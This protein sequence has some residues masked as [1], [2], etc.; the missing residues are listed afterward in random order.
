[1]RLFLLIAFLFFIISVFSQRV[2]IEIERLLNEQSKKAL[3]AIIQLER[4]E[5]ET[6][7]VM[8]Y[9]SRYF[10]I[11]GDIEKSIV[12]AQKGLSR[13]EVEL[14]AEFNKQ[15]M[16]GHYLKGSEDSAIYYGQKL[17]NHSIS[18]T[19]KAKAN[20]LL[21][22][23]H[24]SLGNSSYAKEGYER[25]LNLSKETQD[26]NSV[27]SSLNGLGLIYFQVENQLDKAR[28][29]FFEAVKFTPISRPL[30]KANYLVNLSSVLIKQNRLDSALF[31][32]E[33]SE[34]IAKI[35]KDNGILFSCFV[36]KGVVLLSKNKLILAENYFKNALAL[37]ASPGVNQSDVE[38]LYLSWSDLEYEKGNYK[39]SRDYF[40]KYHELHESRV[41]NE[42]N[43]KIF[44]LQEQ[45]NAAEKKQQIA[46]LEI[47]QQKSE[48]KEKE[49]DAAYFKVRL[50]FLSV[51][52]ALII[53]SI[54]IYIL[55]R[56]RKL[57]AEKSTERE[58]RKAILEAVEKEKYRFSR[59]LHDSLGGTLSMSK[60]MASQLSDEEV[61]TKIGQLLQ[62][63]IDDTRRISRDLYPT[64]LKVSGLKA[65]VDNLFDNLRISN[66][67]VEF[68]FDMYDPPVKLS[69]SFSLHMYRVCQELTNNTIKYANAKNVVLEI[70]FQDQNMF[71]R[72]R[73]NGV[74]IDMNTYKTGV[75]M[76]S[77]QERLA[78]FNS[79]IEIISSVGKGFEISIQSEIEKAE[80]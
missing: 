18:T 79:S 80:E 40:Q 51:I 63:A 66:P 35:I 57:E 22:N 20:V 67:T 77:I 69:D 30:N 44:L 36:N 13:K 10:Q 33:K 14:S 16:I 37:I 64:V 72:Y 27:S 38:S 71:L 28:A 8:L 47:K 65:A 50:I 34:N 11:L 7:K 54:S 46:E 1:M 61:S 3:S 49:L 53:I 58:K 39:S 29:H 15:L 70:D 24:W 62:I 48:L 78:N 43:K 31:Y 23:A 19:E 56:R 55:F 76:N 21:A 74:G 25:A 45:Y 26:S 2:E 59:E 41:N 9:K 60:L 68:D 6:P 4:V 73:D 32:L 42:K 12:F 75:G 17:L 52:A 5:G